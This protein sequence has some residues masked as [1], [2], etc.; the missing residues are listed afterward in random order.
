MKTA[1]R[2]TIMGVSISLYGLYTAFSFTAG[3]LLKLHSKLEAYIKVPL[4]KVSN[5]A[6]TPTPPQGAE[7]AKKKQ[8]GS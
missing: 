4:P 7:P 2:Y 3:V 5:L 1:T 6:P 8:K